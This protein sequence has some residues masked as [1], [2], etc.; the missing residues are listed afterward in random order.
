MS[1]SHI[2][3]A[4]WERVQSVKAAANRH[5][6]ITAILLGIYLGIIFSIALM[7]QIDNYRIA[8]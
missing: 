8:L 1:F 7:A 2:A 5:P 6:L 4:G 3:G